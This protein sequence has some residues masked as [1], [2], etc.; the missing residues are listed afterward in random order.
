MTNLFPAFA[1]LLLWVAACTDLTGR[2]IRN[3]ISIGIFLLFVPYASFSNQM[4]DLPGH[5]IWALAVFAVFFAGFALGK[6]GGGDVKL[7]TVTMLWAG[8]DMGLQFLLVM[9]VSGGVLALTLVLPAAQV[10]REWTL[11]QLARHIPIPTGA[12]RQ[13]VPYGVAIAIGG[14][15][16][17]YGGYLAKGVG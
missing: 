11:V 8:P 1:I 17:L 2:I 3:W 14:T 6:V 5:L 16:A 13:S 12:A 15:V 4:T 9:A 7:A 10:I